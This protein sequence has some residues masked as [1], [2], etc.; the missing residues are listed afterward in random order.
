MALLKQTK[1]T[2]GTILS[3]LKLFLLV[4]TLVS[5]IIYVGY[6]V[7]AIAVGLGNLFVNLALIML[8]TVYTTLYVVSQSSKDKRLKRFTGET[9]HVLNWSK[10]VVKAFDVGIIIYAIIISQD[11]FTPISAILAFI[12][13]LA[14]VVQLVLELTVMYF[15]SRWKMLADAFK[16]DVK[17]ILHPVETAKQALQHSDIGEKV[18]GA[19]AKLGG[20]VAAVAGHPVVAVAINA[21][22]EGVKE[23]IH[24]VKETK[25]NSSSSDKTLNGGNTVQKGFFKRLGEKIGTRK[26][27]STSDTQPTLPTESE[28]EQLEHSSAT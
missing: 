3:E 7:Y 16:D 18:V 21:V 6:L 14:W 13:V 23:V 17:P 9:K 24:H 27:K 4:F 8:T 28:K 5:E 26:K 2:V 1:S 12:T 19:V 20:D 11:R 22:G 15:E 25:S 10:I